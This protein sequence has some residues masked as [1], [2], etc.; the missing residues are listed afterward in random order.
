LGC[1]IVG[2]GV[3]QCSDLCH[4]LGDPRSDTQFPVLTDIFRVTTTCGLAPAPTQTFMQWVQGSPSLGVIPSGLKLHFDSSLM[5]RSVVLNKVHGNFTLFIYGC[6]SII[7]IPGWSGQ[8]SARYSPV[9]PTEIITTVHY[10]YCYY[11]IVLGTGRDS[12]VGIATRYGLDGPG[13]EARWGR[14]FPR[15]C[16]PAVG[17]SQPPLR[18]VADLFPG[19]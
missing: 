6:F 11:Y 19:E 1:I 16:R 10:Y 18:W 8:F 9:F 3:T 12:V 4:R 17:P 14:D 7:R 2:D 15:P 5:L 13:I